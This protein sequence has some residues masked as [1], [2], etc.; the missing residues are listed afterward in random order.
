MRIGRTLPPAA[1]PFS[2]SDIFTAIIKSFKGEV[3]IT[4]FEDE[5]KKYFGVKYC[6]LVTSGKAALTMILTALKQFYPDRTD[7]LI[8]AFTCFS[9][10]AAIKKAGLKMR[11]CDI[12]PKSF[13]FNEIELKAI[14][15]LDKRSGRNNI[16]CVLPT[17]M[18]GNPINIQSLR[19]IVGDDII[20]VE[21]A[22]QAMGGEYHGVK[23]GTLGDISFFSLGRGKALSTVEGGIILTNNDDINRVLTTLIKQVP[24]NDLIHQVKFVINAILLTVMQYPALYWLPNSLPFL[25]LG[26]T[27]FEPDF[28]VRKM[29]AVQA[30]LSRNWQ[31]RLHRHQQNRN[32]NIHFWLD[33]LPNNSILCCLEQQGDFANLIRLPVLASNRQERNSIIRKST[34]LGLGIMPSYPTPINEILELASDFPGIKFP[35]AIE[36]CNRLYTLP[37]HEYVSDEDN[38]KIFELL[39]QNLCSL[40]A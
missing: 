34:Q 25:K 16:L 14:I 35:N 33:K 17:H 10:P 19:E 23:L 12:A 36:L 37:I 38:K 40:S 21:D 18:F 4:R 3:E 27:I 31:E 22:A 6:H 24:S 13:N 1:A 9:V 28:P 20:I 32:K 2:L 15:A 5:L 7:V 39:T 26:E 29:S 11:L 30:A 8:P